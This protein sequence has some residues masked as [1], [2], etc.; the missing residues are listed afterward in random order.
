MYFW[1][2][3]NRIRDSDEKVRDAGFRTLVK[4]LLCCH[5]SCIVNEK[6]SPL[7]NAWIAFT[8]TYAD[9]L[10]YQPRKKVSFFDK[11]DFCMFR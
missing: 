2:R 1:E 5:K 9:R 10:M 4:E 8:L 7:G 6:L 3:K 11:R